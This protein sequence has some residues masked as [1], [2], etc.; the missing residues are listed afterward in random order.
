[1][2]SAGMPT[3]NSARHAWSTIK[4]QLADI[5]WWLAPA[6]C[7]LCDRPGADPRLDLCV[8]CLGGL[9]VQSASWHEATGPWTGI[10]SPW[11]YEYPVDHLVRGLKFRGERVNARVLGTLLGRARA[12]SAAALPGIVIPVP[13]HARRL[14]DRGFNQAAEIAAFAARQLRIPLWTHCLQRQRNTQAQSVLP[15]ARR[16]ANV[17]GAFAANGKLPRVH[18]ALVDDVITTGS[19][20]AA[21][22]TILR[23]AGAASVELWVLAQVRRRAGP[24]NIR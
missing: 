20:A 4:G 19:T 17:S 2:F 22:T 8:H 11:R 21:A 12:A 16:R 15:A 13:L 6:T 10:V 1:M 3:V 5:G 24:A 14:R 7:L 23:E 18:V 9:P